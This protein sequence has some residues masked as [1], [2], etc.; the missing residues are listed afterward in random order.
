MVLLRKKFPQNHNLQTAV[1]RGVRFVLM[2]YKYRITKYDPKNRNEDGHYHVNEWT[3]MSDIGKNFSGNVLTKEEY[4]SVENNYLFALEAFLA[5][6]NVA[7]LNISSLE[8]GE[9]YN[10]VQGQTLELRKILEIARLSLREELWCKLSLNR[11][12]YI[13]FG[14]DYYMYIGVSRKCKKA[15]GSAENKGL[16]VEPYRSPY[17]RG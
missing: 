9:K 14:Y 13:H 12:A 8:G 5:E 6:G 1:V 17:L 11:Q 10:F 7:C 16:F 3:A 15:I 4:L 2:R